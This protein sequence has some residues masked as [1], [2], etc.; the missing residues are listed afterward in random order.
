MD[1]SFDTN[2]TDVYFFRRIRGLQKPQ[3]FCI[4][5]WRTKIFSRNNN[6]KKQ[7]NLW[8]S[9]FTIQRT[10]TLNFFPLNISEKLSVQQKRKN[11]K[12]TQLTI[13]LCNFQHLNHLKGGEGGGGVNKR[14]I[15]VK[16]V[17]NNTTLCHAYYLNS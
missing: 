8:E 13:K 5:V 14:S 11:K 4:F 10:K 1:C 15:G 6:D 9:N 7:R 17:S 12:T 16:W 3:I 2:S